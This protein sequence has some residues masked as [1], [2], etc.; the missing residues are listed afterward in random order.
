MRGAI[1][2]A[3]IVVAVAGPVNAVAAPPSV[4]H[5]M[6]QN[7]TPGLDHSVKLR[8]VDPNRTLDITVSLSLG[9]QPALAT[10]LQQVNNPASP[11]YK[12]YLSA[13]QF[14]ASYGPTPD[15]VQQV[16][17]YLGSQGLNVTSV[18]SNRTL[19]GASGT[20]HAIEGAFSVTISDWHDQR[21]NR[22]FFSN[23]AQPSLPA[24]IA[25]FVVGV[26]GL[27][28][29]SQFH[30]HTV[31]KSLQSPKSAP[32]GGPAGGHT[33]AE[34]K[35]AYDV[36]PL[37]TQGVNGAGQSLGLFE[38]DGFQ[39]T[40][41]TTYDTHY[42][43]A[44][45]SPSVIIVAPGP[46]VT[47]GGGEIEVEL[48]IEVMHAF[49]PKAAITVWEGQNS[50]LGA[51]NTYNAMVTSN[52]TAANSTSWGSCE[53]DLSASLMDTLDQTFQQAAAQG[54]SFFA[55]SGDFGAYDCRNLNAA[56][57]EIVVDYPASDPY[58]TGVG[59]TTLGM[60][61][62]NTSYMSE[63]AWFNSASPPEGSGGGLSTHFAQPAWQTGLGVSNSFSTGFRQVPDVAL[64]GDP[65]SG[66]SI[67]STDNS[68]N[69]AVT[70]WFV[71]GGTSAGA[72]GWA[73]F[74][75]LY[76][77]FAKSLGRGNLGFA[78]PTLYDAAANAP[79]VPYHDIVN[80][81]NHF[82][83][84]G[85]GWD[86]PTGWGTPD[87]AALATAWERYLRLHPGR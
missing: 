43:L 81:N 49:A 51:V 44:T 13:A 14:A 50:D 80:G 20:I 76:N 7:V 19:V 79:F 67:Y 1:V 54:Q 82:Y 30:H 58:M 6:R 28:N 8:P 47:P 85:Q 15:Q 70:G 78:N 87:A 9:H 83:H 36:S 12:R 33:P 23:D 18:S 53:P 41:I 62:T 26:F 35:A 60:D 72:P 17:Q 31:R 10:F 48:D 34:L 22:D 40:N 16:T 84:T 25:P 56:S 71:V 29:H 11:K 55:A 3:G 77:Q 32:G 73:A 42:S 86:Y 68:R 57:N 61:V 38:V 66:Y 52:S 74:A 65:I 2:I 75:A 24:S 37:A 21:L 4:Q 39:Q 69:P 64:D 5:L 45:T 63:A 27:E 59:G 46:G